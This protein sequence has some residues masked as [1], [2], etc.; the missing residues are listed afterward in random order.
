MNYDCN[1]N[2]L[3]LVIKSEVDE[4]LIISFRGSRR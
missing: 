3:L 1:G 2:V 4:K